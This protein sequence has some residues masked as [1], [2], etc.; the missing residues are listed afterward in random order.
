MIVVVMFNLGSGCIKK[1]EICIGD[2][3]KITQ[4][5]PEFENS[6][7][8][9]GGEHLEYPHP[10]PLAK[11]VANNH[12]CICHN[13]NVLEGHARYWPCSSFTPY[14]SKFSK[15]RRIFN[16]CEQVDMQTLKRGQELYTD[17]CGISINRMRFIGQLMWIF[18]SGK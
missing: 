7:E 16:L 12:A 3:V 14:N 13:K 18:I 2:N 4:N 9:D 5:D 6:N 17:P 1:D 10:P 11:N 8:G 15:Q